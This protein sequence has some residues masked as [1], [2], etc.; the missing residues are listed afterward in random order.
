MMS[1]ILEACVTIAMFSTK[2]IDGNAIGRNRM[3]QMGEALERYVKDAFADCLHATDEQHKLNEYQKVYSYLGNQ[4]NPP[5]LI[6]KNGDAIEVKKVQSS[7]PALA[8]NS[9]APKHKLYASDPK[10]TPACRASEESGW[11]EKNIIYVVGHTS[12]TQLK[13]LWM[14]YGDCYAAH[15]SV[16]ERMQ[17]TIADGVHEISDVEFVTTK[18]LGKVKRVDPLGITDLRIRGMWSIAH[19]SK[20]FSYIYQSDKL[21]SFEL[22]VV[23]RKEKYFSFDAFS[24]EKIE[25]CQ[26]LCIRDVKI[27]NPDNPIQLLDAILITLAP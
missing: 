2:N 23:L 15:H 5:D 4:N 20:V 19:P 13:S 17:Q 25:Q 26:K 21:K 1:N 7:A 16:Y 9:S 10:I 6:L 12:D 18:E 22:V 3:N 27:K 14:V 11:T 24:R 8:L